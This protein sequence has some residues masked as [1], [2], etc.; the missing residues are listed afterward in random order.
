MLSDGV[1]GI[2]YTIKSLCKDINIKTKTR[3]LE[4]GF[5]VGEH[6]EILAK[7]L[8]GGVLLVEIRNSVLTIRTSEASCVVV[9][10]KLF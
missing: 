1:S 5:F 8:I 9:I 4:L 2:R 6:V 10:W 7:S 3:L